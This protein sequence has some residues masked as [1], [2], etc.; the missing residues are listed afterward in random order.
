LGPGLFV[1]HRFYSWLKYQIIM[2]V[3][4]RLTL[5]TIFLL[6]CVC[7]MSA[8]TLRV[9]KHLEDKRINGLTKENGALHFLVVGD[10]GRNGQGNQQQ[11]ADWMGVAA[12]Q[13]AAKFVI[14]TGDNFYCCGVASIDDPQW[15]SS[16]E[17]VYRSHSLHIPWYITLGN[18]D[19]NGNVRA[20]INYSGRSQRW[21]LPDRYYTRVIDGVRFIFLD[22]T[23]FIEGYRR[24]DQYPDLHTGHNAKQLQWL[25]SVLSRSREKWKILVGHHP[26]Y[27]LGDHGTEADMVSKLKPILLKHNIPV[28]V[29]GHDHSLQSLRLSGEGVYYLISGGG[30]ERSSVKHDPAITRFGSSTTGFLAVTLSKDKMKVHF[31]NSDGAII[32]EEVIAPAN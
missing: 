4:R 23:P 20:Q 3:S 28:Y 24:S 19:Y 25:D 18:H 1:F 29:S 21:K 17:N 12:A 16:F 2:S 8:Q 31:I 11:V 13:I 9:E 6:L 30:A 26:V 32:H 10:W 7:T 14:S 22:T 5:V 15:I 27:S